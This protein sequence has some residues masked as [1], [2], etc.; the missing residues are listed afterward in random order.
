[1]FDFTA[2]DEKCLSCQVGCWRCKSFDHCED[3]YFEFDNIDGKC[4]CKKGS[5]L[6]NN[7]CLSCNLD[8]NPE[9]CE[10]CNES[11]CTQGKLGPYY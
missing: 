3:C 5:Y 6:F 9:D 8:G 11:G 7:F 2:T 4:F 10:V 1:M